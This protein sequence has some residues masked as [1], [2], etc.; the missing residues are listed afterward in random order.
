[1]KNPLAP[2]NI[3]IFG[4]STTETGNWAK[5]YPFLNMEGVLYTTIPGT[6]LR[7]T[8]DDTIV[9]NSNNRHSDGLCVT[10]YIACD[11]GLE[12]INACDITELPMENGKLINYSVSGA[13]ALGTLSNQSDPVPPPFFWAAAPAG[14]NGPHGIDSQ[15]ALF[16]EHL[17]AS[18][19]TITSEDLFYFAAIGGNDVVPLATSLALASG[20]PAAEPFLTDNGEFIGSSVAAVEALY[21]KGARHIIYQIVGPSSYPFRPTTI[22][23]GLVAEASAVAGLMLNDATGLVGALSTEVGSSGTMPGLDLMLT[24]IGNVAVKVA[25]CPEFYGHRAPMPSDTGTFPGFPFPTYLDQMIESG[26]ALKE[27][28]K[29]TFV[30]DTHFT[31]TGARK[32]TD[33]LKCFI[34]P[35]STPGSPE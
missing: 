27:D 8:A 16:C 14:I 22:K 1:M 18:D 25:E 35:F 15:V 13:T 32:V 24:D 31:Q 12:L 34:F 3:Y 23:A 4:P 21:N 7:K 30:D 26:P 6:N 33:V 19:K 28:R 9:Y 17:D 5:Y 11:C 10:D 2:R 20:N 29:V